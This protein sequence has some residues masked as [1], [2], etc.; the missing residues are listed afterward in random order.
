MCGVG[1][2]P[3]LESRSGSTPLLCTLEAP[4]GNGHAHKTA[5]AGHD[6]HA[7]HADHG[8]HPISDIAHGIHEYAS[9]DWL[10]NM[11]TPGTDDGLLEDTDHQFSGLHTGI[12]TAHV[13][14]HTAQAMNG[15]SHA[16][17]GASG[18]TNLLGGLGMVHGFASMLDGVGQLADGDTANGVVDVAGGG[19]MMAGGA[20]A[21]GAFGSGAA[22]TALGPIGAIAGLGMLGNDYVGEK[23][24]LGKNE[25]GSGRTW[26]DWGTDTVSGGYDSMKEGMGGG[27]GAA[28][29]A[30][31]ASAPLALGVGALGLAGAVGTGVCAAGEGIWEGVKGVGGWMGETGSAIGSGVSDFFSGW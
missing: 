30:G 14:S 24:W 13:A 31:I 17:H 6:P 28:I 20:A 5:T 12:E 10:A 3:T 8:H 25:D 27:T 15:A 2:P 22:A 16:A 9:L 23:G 19:A 11:V 29:A 1:L 7:G 21:L 18:F 4:L 26:A